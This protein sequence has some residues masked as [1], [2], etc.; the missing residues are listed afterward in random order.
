MPFASLTF[1]ERYEGMLVNLPQSLVISEYFNYERFGEMVLALPLDGEERPFTGT[2]ID[3]PG[4]AANARTAANALRR[5]TLD[6]GLGIQN[7]DFVRH[8]NGANFALDNRFRGGDLVENT[9][10]VLGFDFDLYRIQ[11]TGSADYTS[12][13]PRPS[14]PEAVGGSLRVAAMNTLNFFLT[15]DTTAN[16]SGPPISRPSSA[17][18]APSSWPPSPVSTRTSSAST[19]SRTRPASTRSPTSSPA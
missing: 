15:L 10:G 11:P 16:D 8:P 19:R 17:A 5:I 12:V 18:S 9:V 2:A 6:D 3:E 13:N 1:P 7:P 4:A 14:A